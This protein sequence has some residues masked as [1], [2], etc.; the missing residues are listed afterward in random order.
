MLAVTGLLSHDPGFPWVSIADLSERV[1]RETKERITELGARNSNVKLAKEGTLLMSFKLSIGRAAFAGVDLFTNEAIAA[2]EPKDQRVSPNILYYVLPPQ[3][4]SA[5][6]DT[7]VKGA[8][9]NKSSLGKLSITIPVDVA[10]QDRITRIF[11]TIDQAIEK[12]EA[13]IEKYQQIKAGLMHDLFTRGISRDGK[14]RTPREQAPVLYQETPIGWI[15]KEWAGCN[16]FGCYVE[17]ID[18][19]PSHRYPPEVDDGYPI[20][21]TENFDGEDGFNFQKSKCV[22]E[23]I[24]QEQNNRCQFKPDD[25]VFARK[26]KIGMARRYGA[27]KMVFSHTVVLMKPSRA[28]V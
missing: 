28:S 9:L 22:S 13:L 12:T 21:S 10:V 4:K 15:P 8:T 14:L 23:L 20:C 1:V 24:Y 19:N 16:D 17:V 27:D 25:V 18:P 7:A 5:I 2:I 11:Q 6:T 3:A 26:G